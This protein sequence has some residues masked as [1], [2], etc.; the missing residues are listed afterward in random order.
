MMTVGSLWPNKLSF[1]RWLLGM[2]ATG[3][4]CPLFAQQ[5]HFASVSGQIN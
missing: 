2:Q 4:G 5:E 3:P 1:D